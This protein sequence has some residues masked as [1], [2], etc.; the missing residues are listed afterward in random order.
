MQ[1]VKEFFFYAVKGKSIKVKTTLSNFSLKV[2]FWFVL[3]S[4][5]LFKL[6]T[7]I[8]EK[9]ESDFLS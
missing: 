9:I 8:Q 5:F 3:Y 2:V 1:H 4:D 6:I 7:N